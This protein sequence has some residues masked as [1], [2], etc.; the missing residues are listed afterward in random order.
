MD[1]VIRLP[2]CLQKDKKIFASIRLTFHAL[3]SISV[4]SDA[5]GYAIEAVISHVF[6]DASQKAI[7][8]AARSLTP[9]ERN[10]A[11]FEKETLAIIFATM[12]LHKI[13][14]ERKFI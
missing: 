10:Y 2:V 11:Q 1:L 12:K 13:L 8:H 14:Y 4:I 9:V 6:H 7:T 5:S 3:Q